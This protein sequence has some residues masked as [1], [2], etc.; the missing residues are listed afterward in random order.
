MDNGWLGFVLS[1]ASKKATGWGTALTRWPAYLL[2]QIDPESSLPI[3]RRAGKTR[4]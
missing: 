1:H 2:L 4:K 3:R